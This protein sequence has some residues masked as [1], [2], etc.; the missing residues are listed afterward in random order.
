MRLLF[1]TPLHGWRAFAGEVGTILLGVLLALGAQEMVQGLHWRSEVKKTRQGLDAELAR[2]LAAFK[3]RYNNR[4]CVSA[5]L[6]E[7]S[8]WIDSVNA[9]KPLTLR[10]EIEEPPFFSIRSAAWQITD[11]EIASRIP[12]SAKLSYAALYDGLRKYD[13]MKSGES[14]AWSTLNEYGS[15]TRFEDADRR[16][17]KRA[18]KD[19]DDVNN[20][21]A[22]FKTPFDRSATEL[23]IA[24]DP[25]LISNAN[26]LVRQWQK[27]ACQPLL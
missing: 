9:G 18:M 16:A 13:E 12:V 22:A 21:L 17:I 14:E 11:G 10:R 26:P 1:P 27:E 8:R 15:A 25:T 5:R 20:Q 6:A 7:I 24:A 2:D 4:A 3:Q 19:I 23:G